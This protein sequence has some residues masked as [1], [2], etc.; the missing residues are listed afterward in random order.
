MLAGLDYSQGQAVIT[1]DADL[2]HPP[3][4]I[5]VMLDAWQK[6]A[7]VVHAVKESR[8]NDSVVTRMRANVFNNL[9]SWL[10]GIDLHNASDFKLLDR[11]VVDAICLKLPERERFYRGLTDWVGFQTAKVPFT[12]DARMSGEG[13]W[14]LLQLLKLALTAMVSFT[15]APLRIV[16]FMG[17]LTL[18]LALFVGVDAIIT[19]WHG[20]AVSGFAT[21]IIVL[22]LIGSFIMISLGIIGEYIAKIYEEVKGRPSYLVE[23]AAN[24]DGKSLRPHTESSSAIARQ[25]QADAG[26]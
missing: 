20:I 7:M 21:T 2:Q 9:V 4:L 12:V 19:W 25:K 24:I 10:G 17:A 3:E 6:G 11:K 22:L 13:K 8:G 23:R 26:N 18:I 14:S 15:S 5:P 16:T 1:M